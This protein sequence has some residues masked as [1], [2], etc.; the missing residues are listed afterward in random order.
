[1]AE[2]AALLI[3]VNPDGKLADNITHF[4][5]ALRRAGLPVGTGRV[6]DAIRAVE[7]AGFTS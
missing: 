1:M 7:A 4:A 3:P 6:V 2:N 5:R